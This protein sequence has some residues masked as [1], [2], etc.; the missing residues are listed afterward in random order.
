MK[1]PLP[2]KKVCPIVAEL[3][4]GIENR[5]REIE[6]LERKVALLQSNKRENE[7]RLAKVR[8][9]AFGIVDWGIED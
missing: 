4:F 8:Q 3:R 7:K 2:C 9:A 1:L 6:R 5:D